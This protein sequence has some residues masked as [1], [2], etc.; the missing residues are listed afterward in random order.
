M[1]KLYDFLTDTD[2]FV[3][4]IIHGKRGWVGGRS[5][6]RR[7]VPCADEGGSRHGAP[8]AVNGRTPSHS[9]TSTENVAGWAG[10]A[11]GCAA[12]RVPTK[13]ALGMVRI[14]LRTDAHTDTA[15]AMRKVLSGSRLVV[16]EPAN[17]VQFYLTAL[18]TGC[19]RGFLQIP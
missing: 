10:A 3:V 4:G 6:C 13:E 8:A 1:H 9:D 15:G 7:C 12:C 17:G 19:A 5:R 11:G 16:C 2:D 18:G 14:R